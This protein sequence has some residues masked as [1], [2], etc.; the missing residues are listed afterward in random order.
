M[1]F[2]ESPY[3]VLKSLTQFAEVFGADRQAATVREISKLHEECL[4]GTLAE[5][6]EHFTKNEPR[7]EFVIIVAGAGSS[8]ATEDGE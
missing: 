1:I 8:T 4:R 7:G 2:Y 5:L 3:R 6:I